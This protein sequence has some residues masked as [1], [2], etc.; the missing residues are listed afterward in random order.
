MTAKDYCDMKSKYLDDLRKEK[1]QLQVMYEELIQS[2]I[3]FDGKM[4]SRYDT[5][6]EEYAA[7]AELM[8]DSIRRI[9]RRIAQILEMEEGG[10]AVV[11]EVG[12]HLTLEIDGDEAIEA[13]L[14]AD[15][16][17]AAGGLQ[18]ISL[19]SPIGK[20]IRGRHVGE[21]AIVDAPGGQFSV[22]I[23]AIV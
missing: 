22:K 15:T 21:T 17:G 10:E 6:K 9:D 5:Q 7:Q 12:T 23:V 16:G 19:N 14:I 18:L 8:G 13:V 2:S 1:E 20:A 11:A 4:Q 3:D